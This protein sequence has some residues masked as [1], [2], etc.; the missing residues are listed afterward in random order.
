MDANPRPPGEPVRLSPND[1]LAALHR[2]VAEGQVDEAVRARARQRW[3]E[4]QAA[5]EATLPG[6]LL[7]LAERGRPVTVTTSGGHRITGPVVAVGADFGV[8]RDPRLGDAVIPTSTLALVRP[9]PGDD[10]PI[11][12]RAA[13]MVLAFGDAMLELATERPEVIV[14]TA[15]EQFRGDLRSVSP[16]VA[17]LALDGDRRDLVHIALRAI[18]HV[19]VLRR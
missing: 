7:D 6:V 17:V 15:G 1:P 12:N 16:D 18:D 19:I 10:L 5:E 4:R 8:V 9:A 3:L 11:G 14:G 2:W 13:N